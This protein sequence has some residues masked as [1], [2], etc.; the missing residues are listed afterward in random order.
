MSEDGV[1]L[2]RDNAVMLFV[3]DSV[4]IVK[5]SRD[6]RGVLTGFTVNRENDRGVRFDRI[7]RAD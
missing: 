7:E 5:F 4:G 3:G 1:G 2:T 6:A